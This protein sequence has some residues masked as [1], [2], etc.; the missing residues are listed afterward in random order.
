MHDDGHQGGFAKAVGADGGGTPVDD[1][2][3]EDFLLVGGKPGICVGPF[4]AVPGKADG[5]GI[6]FLLEF[7]VF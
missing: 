1:K 4:N 2:G 7:P 6:V 3:F 5:I